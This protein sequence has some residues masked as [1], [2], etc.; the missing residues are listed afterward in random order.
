[1]SERWRDRDRE[2]ATKGG[3]ARNKRKGHKRIREGTG[4]MS[5]KQ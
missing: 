2:R 4:R 1:M 3:R 5:K